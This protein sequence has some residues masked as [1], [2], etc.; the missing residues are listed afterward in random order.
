MID[1]AVSIVEYRREWDQ[2][3][4]EE[5]DCIASASG[6]PRHQIEHIGSTAVPGLIAKPVIDLMVGLA[7]VPPDSDIEKTLVGLGY[8][9]HGEAGVPGRWY[10]TK[11]K[12]QAFNVHVTQLDGT[13]WRNNLAF[14]ELL[15]RSSDARQRYAAVKQQAIAGGAVTLLAYSVVKATVV[16]QLLREGTGCEDNGLPR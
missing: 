1:E 3:A 2:L 10:F 9:A 6:I 12:G 13:H 11:R 5:R 16:D 14:R 7:A 4:A 15:R 8:R